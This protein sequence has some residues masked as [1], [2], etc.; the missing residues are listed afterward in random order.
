[1]TRDV[2]HDEAY[3]PQVMN[4]SP[5]VAVGGFASEGK[6]RQSPQQNN[7]GRV[8]E[9]GAVADQPGHVGQVGVHVDACA[10]EYV[11]IGCLGHV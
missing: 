5:A 3:V 11:C 7:W 9:V 1:M 10:W 6:G 2:T 4:A 8:C